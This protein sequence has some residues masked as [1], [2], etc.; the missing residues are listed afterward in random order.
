MKNLRVVA[1]VQNYDNQEVLQA[2]LVE[3]KEEK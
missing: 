3:V 2:M 1:F